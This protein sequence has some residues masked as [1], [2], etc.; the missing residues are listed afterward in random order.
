MRASSRE[1][2]VVMNEHPESDELLAYSFGELGETTTASIAVHLATCAKCATTIE[3]LALIQ[4]TVRADAAMAP[5]ADA[6]ARVL[7]LAA[8]RAR[9]RTERASAFA[10]LKR[11]VASLTFDGRSSTALAGL[12]GETTAYML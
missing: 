9:P 4:A 12:R 11:V 6:R 8:D 5:S 1:R 3:R 2:G 7:A 10:S